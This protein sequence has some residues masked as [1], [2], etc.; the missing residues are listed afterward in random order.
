MSSLMVAANDSP[1]PF[2]ERIIITVVV[3][4][5]PSDADVDAVPGF[6]SVETGY[7]PRKCVGCCNNA[8]GGMMLWR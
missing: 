8:S 3:D 6:R 4:A 5:P 1:P 2:L 7:A